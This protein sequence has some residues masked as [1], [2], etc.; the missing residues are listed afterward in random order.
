MDCKLSIIVPVY[1]TEKYL[2]KCLDS[3]IEAVDESMEVLIIN[4]GSPDN[5]EEI[6]LEY[7]EKYKTIITYYKKP[8]GGLSDVKNYGLKKA[9]GE[10]VIFLDS[11]D[12]VEQKMYKE[13]LGRAI[14]EDADVVVCDISMVYE[15]GTAS[16]ITQCNNTIRSD[17]FHQVIDTWLVAA[18]W[19]KLVRRKLY[20]GLD[21]P[22]GLNNEDICVTP[23]VLG[24][25]KKI[26]VINKPFYN[27]VQRQGSI[28]NSKF[29]EKRFVI[30]ETAKLALERAQELD[31]KKQII[32]K[33]SL[34]LHQIISIAMYPIR[35]QKFR[36]RYKLLKAYMNKAFELLP[37]ILQTNAYGELVTWGNPILQLY[38]KTTLFLL[39]RKLYGITCVF[40]SLYNMGYNLRKKIFC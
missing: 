6:I 16:C 25:A 18:S 11:D 9:R 8:N 17:V 22:V 1:N 30:L 14:S 19:N 10:Y 2:R 40:W 38:R 24:R 7:C 32:I 26:I 5:S 37:D 35:E 21:F 33:N 39:R 34:Y 4:D 23:I 15:D 13:M 36:D 27:Y 29:N 31:T 20:E 28:Q 12:Y 3:L